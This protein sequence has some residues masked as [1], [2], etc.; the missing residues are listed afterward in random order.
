MAS[1]LIE[2][3]EASKLLSSNGSFDLR[4]LNHE[5]SELNMDDFGN[6]Q[7]IDLLNC[8]ASIFPVT[9]QLG[10]LRR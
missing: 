4:F 10:L 5:L 8:R 2:F 9:C 3:I 7:I 1:K 6:N